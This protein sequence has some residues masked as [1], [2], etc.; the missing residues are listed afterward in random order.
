MKK[1]LKNKIQ[2]F[3]QPLTVSVHKKFQPNRFSRLA[4]CTQHI[5]IYTN[6]FFYYIDY[7]SRREDKFQ[8]LILVDRNGE[9]G[10]AVRLQ[11]PEQG[12]SQG[13]VII[14]YILDSL[15]LKMELMP[16]QLSVLSISLNSNYNYKNTVQGLSQY[17]TDNN[18]FPCC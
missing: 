8:Q 11:Q 4:G 3:F 16:S 6:V 14:S 12:R 17:I 2:N 9:Q 18:V 15:D 13:Q 5:H 10:R 7:L 1:N